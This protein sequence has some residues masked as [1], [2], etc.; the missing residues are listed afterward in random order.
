MNNT[1]FKIREFRQ[2]IEKDPNNAKLFDELAVVYHEMGNYQKSSE[3]AF[4][5]LGFEPENP[6][7]L[8]SYGNSLGWL[9][10]YGEAIKYL[11]KAIEKDSSKAEYYV[12]RGNCYQ[13][14]NDEIIKQDPDTQNRDGFKKSLDDY[15]KAIELEPYNAE[16]YYFRGISYSWLGD[17]EKAHEDYGRAVEINLNDMRYLSEYAI[18]SFDIQIHL[19]YESL[20]LIGDENNAVRFGGKLKNLRENLKNL[21]DAY[22]P[23]IIVKD[24]QDIKPAEVV[25]YADGKVIFQ[26]EAEKDNFEN[27]IDEIVN[28]LER[29]FSREYLKSDTAA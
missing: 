19:G 5:A 20:L 25:M 3:Y 27:I 28:F 24:S 14:I 16:Y 21:Y 7:Y 4:K 15:D 11:G 10:N 22:L 29:L 18:T 12:N 17:G 23:S 2:K 9:G 13:H 26:K 8:A 6:E 1:M